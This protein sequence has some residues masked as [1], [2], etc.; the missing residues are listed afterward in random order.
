MVVQESDPVAEG[1]R[2]GESGVKEFRMEESII[3]ESYS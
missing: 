3:K 2:M 1:F